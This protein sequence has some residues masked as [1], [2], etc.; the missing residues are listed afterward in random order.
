MQFVTIY[1]RWRLPDAPIA[2]SVAPV[3]NQRLTERRSAQAQR[4]L[5][6]LEHQ[7]IVAAES[8]EQIKRRLEEC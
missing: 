7:Q 6:Y 5:E 2:P 3:L 8:L 4:L 1:R